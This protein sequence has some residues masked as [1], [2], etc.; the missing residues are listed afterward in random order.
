[1]DNGTYSVEFSS[2]DCGHITD[3]ELPDFG[4]V[5]TPDDNIPITG[6]CEGVEYNL[7][8]SDGRYITV[9]DNEIKFASRGTLGVIGLITGTISCSQGTDFDIRHEF[10]ILGNIP[11]ESTFSSNI[12]TVES[13]SIEVP[14]EFTGNGSQMWLVGIDGPLSRVAETQVD[15]EL[16]EG[17][18]ITLDINPS[19]LLLDGMIVGKLF[20]L[21]ILVTITTSQ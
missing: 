14:V 17:S 7:T 4:S 13:S 19:G 21:Q 3:I 5:L 1:M 12:P 20:W 18:A 15:Q 2:P 11:I 6:N 10:E 9:E 8:S 16:S